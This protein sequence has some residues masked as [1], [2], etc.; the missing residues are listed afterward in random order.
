MRR[1]GAGG[2]FRTAEPV[3]NTGEGKARI[4]VPRAPDGTGRAMN[5]SWVHPMI[6]DTKHDDLLAGRSRTG[7]VMDATALDEGAVTR[8]GRV[9]DGHGET[10]AFAKQG[11]NRQ[12]DG[13]SQTVDAAA[14]GAE[15]GVG[16]AEVVGDAA[17]AEPGGDGASARSSSTRLSRSRSLSSCLFGYLADRLKG[18]YQY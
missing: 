1:R 10:F 3:L 4:L 11:P 8:R 15:R 14:G 9:V 13:E 7:I 2:G 12:D 17:G 6:G 16:R 5:H 18:R